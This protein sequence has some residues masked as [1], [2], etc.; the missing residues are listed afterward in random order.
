LCCAC[1]SGIKRLEL[2]M[3]LVAYNRK[4][5]RKSGNAFERQNGRNKASGY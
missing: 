5:E 3:M 1:E 4:D 2:N